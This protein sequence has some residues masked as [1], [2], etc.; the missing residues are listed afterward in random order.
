M[1]GVCFLESVLGDSNRWFIVDIHQSEKGDQEDTDE[2]HSEVLHHVTTAVAQSVVVGAIGAIA[3]S[4]D[5]APDG[6]YLVEFTGLP[7]T[8]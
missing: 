4:D 7:Y 1:V 8:D 6:Y 2:A 5:E 3:T